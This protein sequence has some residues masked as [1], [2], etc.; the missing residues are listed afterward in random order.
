MSIG[1]TRDEP[2]RRLDPVMP[3]TVAVMCGRPAGGSEK[4]AAYTAGAGE[5]FRSLAGG[6]GGCGGVAVV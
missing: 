1:K 2:S 3:G 6:V 5:I 4:G